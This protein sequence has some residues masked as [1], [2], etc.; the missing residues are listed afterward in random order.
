MLKQQDIPCISKISSIF[1][2]AFEAPLPTMVGAVTE[3][4]RKLLSSRAPAGAGGQY[5]HYR[6]SLICLRELKDGTF[7]IV[8]L[9]MFYESLGWLKI[10][11]DGEYAAPGP[12]WDEDV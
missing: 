3:W 8:S 9:K 1:E 6:P 11:E 2:I 10:I 12:I 4:D 5:T 7:R